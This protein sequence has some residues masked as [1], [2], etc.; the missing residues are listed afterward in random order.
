[1]EEARLIRA[2]GDSSFSVVLGHQGELV[3]QPQ[4]TTEPLSKSTLV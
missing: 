3:H 4:A 2:A 1:M